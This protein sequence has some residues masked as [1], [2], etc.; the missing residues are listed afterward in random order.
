MPPAAPVRTPASPASRPRLSVDVH[1]QTSSAGR[2]GHNAALFALA[3]TALP[4]CTVI[5]D[6]EPPEHRTSAEPRGASGGGGQGGDEG[7]AGQA[8]GIPGGQAGAWQ[9][10]PVV[11]SAQVV[12]CDTMSKIPGSPLPQVAQGGGGCLLL[13]GTGLDRLTNASVGGTLAPF[14]RPPSSSSALLS[15]EVPH[16]S[17]LGPRALVL[18]FGGASE[19]SGGDVLEATAI[20]IASWGSDSLGLGTPSRP[21][22]TLVTAAMARGG[23][24]PGDVLRL[25]GDANFGAGKRITLPANSSLDGQGYTLDGAM[26]EGAELWSRGAIASVV[27][28]RFLSAGLWVVSGATVTLDDVVLRENQ[29]GL[30]IGDNGRVKATASHPGACRFESNETEGVYIYNGDPKVPALEA[31]GCI[32]QGNGA[33]GLR[34]DY[35]ARVVLSGGSVEKNSLKYNDD[36]YTAGL[37]ASLGGSAVLVGVEVRDNAVNNV[38]MRL[39]PGA[40]EMTGGTLAGGARGGYFDGGK[41]T[42]TDVVAS[43]AAG[44]LLYATNGASLTLK[45]TKKGACVIEKAGWSGV[46][47]TGAKIELQGCAI[48]QNGGFGVGVVGVSTGTLDDVEVSNNGFQSS[49]CDEGVSVQDTSTLTAHGGVIAGNCGPDLR[50]TDAASAALVGVDLASPGV[51]PTPSPSVELLDATSLTLDHVSLHDNPGAPAVWLPKGASTART[52]KLVGCSFSQN[53]AG[54]RDESGSPLALVV[55]AT[56]FSAH[57]LE[58][59]SSSSDPSEI[60]LSGC[61]FSANN[62]AAD[63]AF[64]DLVFRRGAMPP[65]TV[66]ALSFDGSPFA[67]QGTLCGPSA[68]VVLSSKTRLLNAGAGCVAW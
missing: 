33:P 30:V 60:S 34:L 51:A 19:V 35:G 1:G 27:L 37:A 49:E 28:R 67:A 10:E 63:G 62:T 43:G 48:R 45:G 32:F 14:A 44:D 66:A 54:L 59:L 56:T 11:A 15:V 5:F 25:V 12:D 52:V 40:F 36:P 38:V 22:A 31:T 47:A 6:L 61:D 26:Q 13:T 2:R 57:T 53:K 46:Y 3:I 41:A 16:G 24:Q 4:A 29:K 55:E 42:L 9:G 21:Y 8:G 68:T 64:A 7:G 18:M 17:P 50:M 39:D 58:G 65:A 20:S 23:V